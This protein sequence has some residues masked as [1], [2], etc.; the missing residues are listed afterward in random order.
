[1]PQ[2]LQGLRA[3]RQSAV[4]EHDPGQLRRRRV[5]GDGVVPERS[6]PCPIRVGGCPR[7]GD[8]RGFSCAVGSEHAEDGSGLG[9]E[10][11][12]VD[13][14]VGAVGVLE[15]ANGQGRR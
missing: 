4:L 2:H 7:P 5:F 13:D 1:M 15:T 3:H 9:R 11:D 10:V 14:T 12:S 8:G 6:P